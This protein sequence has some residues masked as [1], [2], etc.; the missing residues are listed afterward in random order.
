MASIDVNAIVQTTLNQSKDLAQ[1]LF[2]NYAGQAEQDVKDFLQKSQAGIQRATELFLE[3]KIDKEDLED[4][5]LGKKD[6][7][8]MHALKQIGLAKA[9]V[10]TFVNGVLQILVDAVFAAVKI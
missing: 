1:T 5:V 6:L 10:D 3:K 2:R 4:L 9:A 7:A 8:E